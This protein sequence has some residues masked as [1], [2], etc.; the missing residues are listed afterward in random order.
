M[1]P[2]RT[3]VVED[4]PIIA[5]AHQAYVQ[6]V[7]GFTAVGVAHTG[8]GALRMLASQPIDL[9]LL[10]FYLPDMGGLDVCRAMRAGGHSADVIAVTSAR[11]LDTVRAAVSQGVV[12]YVLK[13][14]AFATLR[15]R[16]E[17]YAAYRRQIA[18]SAEAGDQV[19][20]DRALAV[21]RGSSEPGTPKGLSATTLNIVIEHV[22]SHSEQ[23]SASDVA[24]LAGVSRV[25]ARR[26]LE[27]LVEQGLADRHAR[28]G[29]GRPEHLYLWK[30]R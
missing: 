3:L 13:P 9:V 17:R 26:Y 11:Q 12:Q 2:I 21:L 19:D 14:F 18:G 5:E 7:A 10:D 20:V 28:Y 25:T 6:R 29:H 22:R 23:V 15:D 24:E 4:E 1:S 30:R 27:H 16:L 8:A